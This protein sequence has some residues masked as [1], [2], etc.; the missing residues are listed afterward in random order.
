MGHPL[1][2]I[3]NSMKGSLTVQMARLA[4]KDRGYH[5]EDAPRGGAIN[6]N[7]SNS[8]ECDYH[9]KSHHGEEITRR[10]EVKCGKFVFASKKNGVGFQNVK[11]DK[12]DDLVLVVHLPWGVELWSTT[13]KPRLA[14]PRWASQ[15][16][17][18]V[19]GSILLVPVEENSAQVQHGEQ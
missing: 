18:G 5:T 4:D 15:H 14:L 9:R 6:G 8:G 1:D 7:K 12:F 10:V 17:F 11:F 19:I 2:R 16:M 3:S 13:S